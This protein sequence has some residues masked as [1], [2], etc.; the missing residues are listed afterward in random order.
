MLSSKVEKKEDNGGI[1]TKKVISTPKGKR[2]TNFNP[3]FY[4]RLNKDVAL[5]FDS[6]ENAGLQHYQKVIV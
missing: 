6:D 3:L 5:S 1:S 2:K 4:N